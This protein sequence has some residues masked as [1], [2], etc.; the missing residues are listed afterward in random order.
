[1]VKYYI[2]SKFAFVYSMQMVEYLIVGQGLAGSMLGWELYKRG[3][4][5][6]V[7]GSSYLPSSTNVAAGLIN[8]VNFRTVKTDW[9]ANEFV[10][11]AI[12]TYSEIENYFNRKLLFTTHSHK[13]INKDARSQWQHA[14]SFGIVDDSIGFVEDFQPTGF[15]ESHTALILKSAFVKGQEMMTVLAD[16]FRAKGCYTEAKMDYSNILWGASAATVLGIKAKKVVFCEGANAINNPWFGHAG[17]TPN[18]GELIE[19]YVPKLLLD[20]L[21]R[22]DV[23]VLPLGGGFFKVGAT[24]SHSFSNNEPSQE[25]LAYLTGKLG[26]M[27]NVPFQ[28]VRHYAGMRPAVRDRKPIMGKHPQKKG[29]FIFNGLGSK[30]F[31]QAP[32]WANHFVDWLEG[33][34]PNLDPKVN[35]SRFMEETIVSQRMADNY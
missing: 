18:K 7:V 34:I 26:G 35:V 11:F 29:M 31:V 3:I 9:M 20:N 32:Y 28:V 21:V 4:S 5:F 12:S 22:G 30:G 33:R 24:Y 13:L 15:R 19:V 8:T 1:M 2:N 6:H 16:F 25:A 14:I 17:L 10:P 23:F 27:L